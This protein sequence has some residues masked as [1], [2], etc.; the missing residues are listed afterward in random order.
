MKNTIKFLLV[1]CLVFFCSF[2]FAGCTY[3]GLFDNVNNS[4]G[5]TSETIPPTPGS[6]EEPTKPFEPTEPDLPDSGNGDKTME[7][8]FYGF[9]YLSDVDSDYLFADSSALDKKAFRDLVDRQINVFTQDLIIRLCTVYGAGLPTESTIEE[10]TTYSLS[11]NIKEYANTPDELTNGKDY[12]APE[13]VF[14]NGV[15]HSM[16]IAAVNS[17]YVLDDLAKYSIGSNIILSYLHMNENENFCNDHRNNPD[18]NCVGCY[19]QTIINGKYTNNLTMPL[20][21]NLKNQSAIYGGFVWNNATLG[22]DGEVINGSFSTDKI[23]TNDSWAIAQNGSEVL[24]MNNIEFYKHFYSE[25][26][27]FIKQG[28]ANILAV[29][30]YSAGLTYEQALNQIN[31]L[32]FLAYEEKENEV[33]IDEQDNVIAFILNE[34]VGSDLV[35]LDNGRK[36]ANTIIDGRGTGLTDENH[37]YKA[38]SLL[39]PAICEQSFNHLFNSRIQNFVLPENDFTGDEPM[40]TNTLVNLYPQMGRVSVNQGDFSSLNRANETV[41][42]AENV[43]E[44]E[45]EELDDEL[46]DFIPEPAFTTKQ[47]FKS[48]VLKPKDGAYVFSALFAMH[49]DANYN[50]KLQ[51]TFK[52]VVNGKVIFNGKCA[53]VVGGNSDGTITVKKGDYDGELNDNSYEF[54]IYKATGLSGEEF[55]KTCKFGDY[56]GTQNLNETIWKNSLNIQPVINSGVQTGNNVSLNAGNNYFEIGISV[57]EITD[58]YGEIVNNYTPQFAVGFLEFIC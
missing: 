16:N 4:G 30:D 44:L 23:E 25:A 2:S 18:V 55:L 35:E 38:Y 37:R 58:D 49:G 21:T 47:N 27:T 28:I 48:I 1:C 32:G 45:D 5:H 8:L 52:Y 10:N 14:E 6:T 46:E 24:N 54:D 13:N 42:T 40:I 26:H 15:E 33:V 11:T 57:V 17:Q 51:L 34:V 31:H 12:T 3:G 43:D 20:V 50:L 41:L 19:A 53:N 7:D 9:T 39:I 36:P 56:S 22:E 29:G